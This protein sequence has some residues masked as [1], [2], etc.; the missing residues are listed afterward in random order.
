MHWR[1]IHSASRVSRCLA[2]HEVSK[3]PG[4]DQTGGSM[5]SVTTA[6]PMTGAGEGSPD[7]SECDAKEICDSIR[8]GI[9]SNVI[10]DQC[11]RWAPFKSE[12]VVLLLLG[13]TAVA[14]IYGLT[15]ALPAFI[16][17]HSMVSLPAFFFAI[18]G[19]AS[20][21]VTRVA[22]WQTVPPYAKTVVS[23][24]ASAQVVWP[25]KVWVRQY[26]SKTGQVVL[27]AVLAVGS[28]LVFAG[29]AFGQA[30]D[31]S[32]GTIVLIG[33]SAACVS[34]AIYCALYVPTVCRVYAKGQVAMPW[35]DPARTPIIRRGSA[36]FALLSLF[37][38]IIFGITILGFFFAQPWVNSYYSAL[39]AIWLLVGLAIITYS[40]VVPH[41]YMSMMIR[42]ARDGNLEALLVEIDK[43]RAESAGSLDAP[44]RAVAL[45]ALYQQLKSGSG[46]S[47]DLGALNKFVGTILIPIIS[48]AV[49]HAP[50]FLHL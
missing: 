30:V 13:V 26:S 12:P 14:A 3:C 20:I 49:A 36:A 40:F 42:R 7:Q 15:T 4:A 17:G 28:M 39:A 43:A 29:A 6:L 46:T 34:N 25:L 5:N 2:R 44:Q 37:E 32:I 8:H 41:Y 22:Y 18:V 33:I 11:M 45:G 27:G 16:A 38:A 23:A 24:A 48:F 31:L 35:L 9:I 21:V 10:V 47:V 19:P 1:R 50:S